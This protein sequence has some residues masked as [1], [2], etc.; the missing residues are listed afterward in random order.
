MTMTNQRISLYIITFVGVF[1]VISPYVADW[2][3]THI[4][5]PRWPP[6]AKFHNAQTMLLGTLLG[7]SAVGFAWRRATGEDSRRLALTVAVLLA[8]LYWITQSLSLLFPGTAFLDPE[9][10][11]GHDTLLGLPPQLLVDMVALSLLAVAWRLGVTK[12][13]TI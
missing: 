6:H 2:N 10:R 1:T 7:L 3:V 13:S 9:F 8:G 4:Y 11:T 12:T 5:N